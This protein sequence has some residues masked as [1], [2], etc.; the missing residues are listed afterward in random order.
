MKFTFEYIKHNAAI[1]SIKLLIITAFISAI[2]KGHRKTYIYADLTRN[3]D[4][5]FENYLNAI[6]ETSYYRPAII[7]LIPVIGVFFNTKIGWILIQSYC[8]FLISQVL[9][10]IF[11]NTH[12]DI[13]SSIVYFIPLI[14][15]LLIILPMNTKMIRQNTYYIPKSNSLK[16]NTVAFSI[17][18]VITLTVL[19]TKTF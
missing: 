17:G 12:I 6:S 16:Y 10:F 5:I 14:P 4:S 13:A 3:T 1:F 7:L 8:Y 9:Y 2:I 19:L 18:I 11:V 15:L